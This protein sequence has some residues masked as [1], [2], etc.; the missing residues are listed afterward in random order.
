VRRM[1]ELKALHSKGIGLTDAHLIA[2][3]LLDRSALLWTNDKRLSKLAESLGIV[4]DI[5]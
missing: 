1:I 3:C 4:A 2:S 5:L